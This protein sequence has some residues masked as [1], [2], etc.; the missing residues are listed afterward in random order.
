MTDTRKTKNG[1]SKTAE[2]PA[3]LQCS[4]FFNTF[5]SLISPNVISFHICYQFSH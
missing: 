1:I 4:T 5:I 2:K 3:G